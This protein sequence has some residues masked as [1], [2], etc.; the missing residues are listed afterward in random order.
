MGWPEGDWDERTEVEFEAKPGRA[1][2][3]D[4]RRSRGHCQKANMPARPESQWRTSSRGHCRMRSASIMRHCSR[5]RRRGPWCRAS[6]AAHI[7]HALSLDKA[8]HKAKTF[9]HNRILPPRHQ[10]LPPKSE[11]CYPCLRYRTSP[12]SRVGQSILR[13]KFSN[14]IL[15]PLSRYPIET[16]LTTRGRLAPPLAS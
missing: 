11:T 3:R 9:L 2:Q 7:P 4:D 1:S 16:R 6:I 13:S 12:M 8:S 15:L 14:R 5:S 10:H